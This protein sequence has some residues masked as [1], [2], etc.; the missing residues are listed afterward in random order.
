MRQPPE[1][2]QTFAPV[3]RSTHFF[4]QQFESP[5]QGYPSS[6]QPPGAS[7]QRPGW[8]PLAEHMLE[9]Q[10][11]SARQMSP[12]ALQYAAG[13]QVPSLVPVPEA[14][15][16]LVEQQSLASAQASPSVVHAPPPRMAQAPPVQ[17][18]EQHCVPLAQV[19]PTGL[20]TSE[21]QT[22][23][24]VPAP[25]Q[26]IEQHWPSELH[27]SPGMRHPAGFVHVPPEPQVPE[28]QAAAA[29][30][31]HAVPSG[32][33]VDVGGVSQVRGEAGVQ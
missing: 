29:A 25:V 13:L 33:Q 23:P 21:A 27:A 9:Q 26:V 16:Q 5:A 31:V 20:Q 2:W 28:Q 15:W 1:G 12:V 3:P 11:V 17:V 8:P 4:V 19:E 18:P 30:A 22:A 7:M 24:G 32:W 14:P 10:S 6:A